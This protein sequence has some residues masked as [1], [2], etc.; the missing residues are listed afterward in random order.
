[1]GFS[2]RSELSLICGPRCRG[3]RG[4]GHGGVS[5]PSFHALCRPRAVPSMP[6]IIS[7]IFTTVRVPIRAVPNFLPWFFILSMLLWNYGEGGGH[8]SSHKHHHERGC[9][10]NVNDTFHYSPPFPCYDYAKQPRSCQGVG[11]LYSPSIRE[12]KFPETSCR[13]W[14]F[15]E[16]PKPRSK[17][18]SFLPSHPIPADRGYRL[19]VQRIADKS[20]SRKPA[21]SELATYRILT[22]QREY[23]VLNGGPVA[24]R[25]GA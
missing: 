12:G 17:G 19:F 11:S 2:F 18:P 4:V 6:A 5:G 24:G 22:Q 7:I 1:M 16:T 21:V 3:H 23:L 14:S 20:S 9:R 8:R 15:S 25:M 13:F 10:K